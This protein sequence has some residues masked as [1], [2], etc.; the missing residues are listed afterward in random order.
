MPNTN[1]TF[2][3]GSKTKRNNNKR[4][5]RSSTEQYSP[6]CAQYEIFQ[7]WEISDKPTPDSSTSSSPIGLGLLQF[8]QVEHEESKREYLD[9]LSTSS[10]VVTWYQWSEYPALFEVKTSS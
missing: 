9:Y 10:W 7:S 3:I 8:H 5:V 2:L 1:D 6:Q 4:E